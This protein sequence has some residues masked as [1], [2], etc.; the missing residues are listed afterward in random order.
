MK[1]PSFAP[2]YLTLFPGLTKVARKNG[3]A[4][5]VHGSVQRDLDLV[6]I[7]WTD[8]AT[9]AEQLIIDIVDYL[10]WFENMSW[11]SG[12]DGPTKK[13]HGRRSWAILTGFGSY[14]DLSVMPKSDS[15]R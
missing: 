4:L 1:E 15:D 2:A 6:A 12:L 14:V 10:R 3:Y 13:P 8:K 11:F 9:S 7:P 5:A